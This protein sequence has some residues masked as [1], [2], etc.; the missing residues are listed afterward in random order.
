[1]RF[2]RAYW[3]RVTLS[4]FV[5]YGELFFDYGVTAKNLKVILNFGGSSLMSTSP[6]I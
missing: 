3:G 5:E 1:M 6:L 4:I 2:W